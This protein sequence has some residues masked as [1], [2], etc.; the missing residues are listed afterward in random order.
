MKKHDPESLYLGQEFKKR[1]F[2]QEAK[3][4]EIKFQE[5]PLFKIQVKAEKEKHQLKFKKQKKGEKN[6]EDSLP[7]KTL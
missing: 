5:T 4:V 1:S 2:P 3:T 6:D 7:N